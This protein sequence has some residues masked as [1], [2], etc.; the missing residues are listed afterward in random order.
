M[1]PP[2]AER[3][4]G[5]YRLQQLLEENDISRT[6][7]AEQTSVA[8]S[9]IVDELRPDRPYRKES[10]LADIRAKAAVDHRLRV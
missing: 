3:Q 1:N 8:R 5:E 7:L 4:L 6:W 9:V 10:F 2:S